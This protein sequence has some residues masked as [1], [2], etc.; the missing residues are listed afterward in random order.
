MIVAL[1]AP[2]RIDQLEL[3][4]SASIGI[5]TYPQDGLT[6]E[7]LIKNADVAKYQA[8]DCGRNNYQLFNANSIERPSRQ[9]SARALDSA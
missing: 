5:A 2:Y 4:V 1:S 3:H 9:Y 7:T 8:K 6:A